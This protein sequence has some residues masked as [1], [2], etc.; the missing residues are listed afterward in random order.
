M[1]AHAMTGNED[2]SLQAGMNSHVSKPFDP[3]QLFA[4]LQN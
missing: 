2:K 1:T 4:T 3:D